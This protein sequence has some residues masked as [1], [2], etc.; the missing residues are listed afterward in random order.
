MSS[1]PLYKMYASRRQEYQIIINET[2]CSKRRLFGMWKTKRQGGF[3]YIGVGMSAALL[4]TYTE[5]LFSPGNV[6]LDLLA[7]RKQEVQ[8]ESSRL[9]LSLNFHFGWITNGRGIAFSFSIQLFVKPLFKS[10]ILKPKARDEFIVSG[11]TGWHN[12]RI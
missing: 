8:V 4:R 9:D 3:P 10:L 6:C 11:M 12:K 1:C 5:S 2:L 7:G